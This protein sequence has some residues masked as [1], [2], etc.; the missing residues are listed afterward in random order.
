MRSSATNIYQF[1]DDNLITLTYRRKIFSQRVNDFFQLPQNQE[2][3]EIINLT[4]TEINTFTTSGS[5]QKVQNSGMTLAI[6]GPAGSQLDK[7]RLHSGTMRIAFTSNFEH[8]GT[9]LVVMPEM[10]QNG[11]PFSQT[12]PIDFQGGGAISFNIDI[13]LQGYEM[14]LDNGG[15]SNT[16]PINYTLTLNQGNGAAPNTSNIVAITHSFED[17][18][19]AFADGNFGNFELEVAPGQVDLDVLQTDHGGALYFEDP[20]LRVRITNTFGA[21]VRLTIEDFFASLGGQ[22]DL[23]INLNA[24]IPGNQFT[25]A[26]ATAPGDSSVLEYLFNKDNS[27]VRDVINL[28]YE[29]L[30]HDLSAEVNPKG[31]AYNFA[32]G[33]SAIEVVADME[34]PFWGYSNNFTIVDTVEVPFDEGED[35]AENVQKL[36]LR[37]NTLSHFPVDGSLKLFF[38][39]SNYTLIDSVLT[40]G[41]FLIRSGVLNADGKV[42]EAVNSNTDIE[43][44]STRIRS[45]FNSQY[46]LL[47]VNIHTP[48]APNSNIK[49]FREDNIEMRIGIRVKLKASPSDLDGF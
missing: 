29:E 25:I 36:L 41:E 21:E 49:I 13:P 19:M 14:D 26:P 47:H 11:T 32:T 10:R 6:S 15:G 34:L 43:L 35:F 9:L 33:T 1:A 44:D 17:M 38:A 23:D 27:N 39:D 8:S 40:N 48:D 3:N 42:T 20:S 22:P 4:P 46:M 5:V 18:K 12:Y 28:Q 45:L 37:I 2:V 16:I 30:N 24:L 7:L 31:P